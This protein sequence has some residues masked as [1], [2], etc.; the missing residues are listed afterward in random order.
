M[1]GD[2]LAEPGGWPAVA[3]TASWALPLTAMR[4]F[5][6]RRAAA[7]GP[8]FVGTT[9]LVVLHFDRLRLSTN[10]K[11]EPRHHV[12]SAERSDSAHLISEKH[13]IS[14][15][16]CGHHGLDRLAHRLGRPVARRDLL[17]PRPEL[18]AGQSV[19]LRIDDPL[20]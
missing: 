1:A 11:T 6:L 20:L 19:L 9:A 4:I 14:E 13:P 7:A 3:M 10:S 17:R 15:N 18:L 8:V 16:H 5:A 12:A 2:A